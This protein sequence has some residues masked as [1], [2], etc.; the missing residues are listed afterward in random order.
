MFSV[1]LK[2]MRKDRKERQEDIAKLLKVQRTTVGEYERGNIVP[3]IDKIKILADHFEVSV[4]YL[5]GNTNFRTHEERQEQNALDVCKS[6]KAILDDLENQ[7]ALLIF[8]GEALDQDS[9][10]I[11]ISNIQNGLK[12]VNILNHER[13]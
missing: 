6:L 9:R 1:R 10:D 8:N 2:A 3:P 4:D 5:M 7:Q 11:L 13:T 12:M